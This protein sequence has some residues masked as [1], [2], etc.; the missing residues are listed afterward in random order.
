MT[1][2]DWMRSERVTYKPSDDSVEDR[3]LRRCWDAAAAAERERWRTWVEEA[4][5]YVG[6]E[7]WSPSL[8]EEGERLLGLRA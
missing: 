7:T 1:F 6:C 4:V 5:S 3:T 8:K 2:E